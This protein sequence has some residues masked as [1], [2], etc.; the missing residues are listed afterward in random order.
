MT[1]GEYPPGKTQQIIATLISIIQYAFF[2]L[3][4]IGETIFN[5]LGLPV[6]GIKKLQ[7]NK[8]MYIMGSMF[9][10]N[11][12]KNGLTQTGAFEVYINNN[13]AFSKLETGRIF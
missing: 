12:I 3:I 5:M 9:I 4:L 1:G 6:E 11:T 10:C 13:L 8:W 7:E 2:A